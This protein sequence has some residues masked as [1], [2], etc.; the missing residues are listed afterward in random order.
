LCLFLPA[1]ALPAAERAANIPRTDECGNIDPSA[2]RKCVGGRI[3]RK[4]RLM[5]QQLIKAREAVARGFARHGNNDNRTDPR[6][7]DASQEAW[8]RYVES[9][10]TVIAAYPGGSNSAISDR[11]M[12]C[13]EEELDRRLQFLRDVSEGTGPVDLVG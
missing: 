1:S 9:N 11:E 6:Y 3:D 12:Y 2:V 13:Y 5:S 8:K 10:C 7:L 4:E